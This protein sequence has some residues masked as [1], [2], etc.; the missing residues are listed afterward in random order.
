MDILDLSSVARNVW[1][2]ENKVGYAATKS[3]RVSMEVEAEDG[4]MREYV[5]S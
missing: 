5:I 3:S 1:E 4:E 2:R